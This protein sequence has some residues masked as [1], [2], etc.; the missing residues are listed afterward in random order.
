MRPWYFLLF[1]LSY[2][3]LPSLPTEHL[4]STSAACCTSHAKIGY[5][6]DIFLPIA[7]SVANL[8]VRTCDSSLLTVFSA[9]PLLLES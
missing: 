3:V 9:L 6:I 8:S 1:S 5:T 7:I 2:G 4:V